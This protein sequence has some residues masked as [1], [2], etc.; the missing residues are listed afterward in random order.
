M[1]KHPGAIPPQAAHEQKLGIASR[2]R[3]NA[4]QGSLAFRNGL[5]E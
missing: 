5:P 1:R 4:V 2:L 3:N